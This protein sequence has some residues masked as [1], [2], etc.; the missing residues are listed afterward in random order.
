MVEM[1]RR[2]QSGQK[3]FVSESLFG[4]DY[5]WTTDATV[6]PLISPLLP[7]LSPLA[8]TPVYFVLVDAITIFEFVVI[9]VSFAGAAAWL[10]GRYLLPIS[11]RLIV[12]ASLSYAFAPLPLLF[13][14][15]WMGFVNPQ[16]AWP[17]VFVA[18]QLRSARNAIALTLV[19]FL[20]C[21]FGGSL[22]P[23]SYLGVGSLAWAA[24]FSWRDRS[25]RPLVCLTVAILLTVLV[26]YL[27]LGSGAESIASGGRLRSF[28]AEKSSM[29]NV[30]PIPLIE[31]FFL[32]PFAG[33]L[34]GPASLFGAGPPWS[35]AIAYSAVNIPLVVALA[36]GGWRRP[37]VTSVLVALCVIVIFIWRPSW[38]GDLVAATPVLRSTRWPF[39]EV[40]VLL[41]HVHLLFLFTYKGLPP[42]WNRTIWLVALIPLAVLIVS[43]APTLGSVELSRRLIL[44]GTADNYWNAVRPT[45]GPGRS[46]VCMERGLVDVMPE[47]LPFPLLPSHNY[48]ALFGVVSVSGYTS[49][50]PLHL[51]QTR[52][53]PVDVHGIYTPEQARIYLEHFPDTRVTLLRRLDPPVWSII[54]G[55][56][57]RTF[58]LDPKT[59]VIQGVDIN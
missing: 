23:F 45:L 49:S 33:P 47:V 16:A 5:D 2:I 38:L 17:L 34:G 7:L 54:E 35:A 39:R 8:R 3:A 46:L 41:F 22:H 58:T 42:L 53:L 37:P 29:L 48:P 30:G 40:S 15:S 24:Y 26:V 12:G 36:R 21:V 1:A 31:S 6:F 14:T 27:I 11:D 32:G 4:G 51:D 55:G 10:R 50:S 52:M 59:L 20:F 57:E 28:S 13:G 25:P 44:S 9:A 43:G 19:A 18:L 56:T